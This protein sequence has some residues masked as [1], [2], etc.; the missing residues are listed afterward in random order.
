M[1]ISKLTNLTRFLVKFNYMKLADLYK[2]Y[3]DTLASKHIHLGGYALT[4]MSDLS[5][6]ARE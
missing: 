6:Q 2:F 3:T 1:K 5:L 4:G